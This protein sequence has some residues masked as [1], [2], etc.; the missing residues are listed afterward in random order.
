MEAS[1]C[2]ESQRT[3][4][5]ELLIGIESEV[6]TFSFLLIQTGQTQVKIYLCQTTQGGE[7]G[8]D[9]GEK[10][11]MDRGLAA[12]CSTFLSHFLLFLFFI[13]ELARFV[14]LLNVLSAPQHLFFPLFCI[15]VST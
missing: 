3:V 14:F 1:E 7:K 11:P 9:E 10:T 4:L 12:S 6:E 15:V 2:E 13:S 8:L 5:K